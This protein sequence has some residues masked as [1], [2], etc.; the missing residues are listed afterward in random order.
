MYTGI[1]GS[2][3]CSYHPRHP[4]IGAE[5]LHGACA[6]DLDRGDGDAWDLANSVR[7]GEMAAVDLLDMYLARV[8]RLDPELNAS[9]PRR[10]RCARAAAEID[11]EVARGE[12]PGLRA[13]VPMG[14]KE[15]AK[16]AGFPDTH[17]SLLYRDEVAARDGT[18]A[19]PARCGSGCSSG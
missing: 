6:T 18:E 10:R 5:R 4:A 11:A 2:E 7:S 17:A 3:W 1:D 16:V 15:L 8:E 12:D 9:L 13:G 19:A 14:V